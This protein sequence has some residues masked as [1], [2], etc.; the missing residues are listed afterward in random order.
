MFNISSFFAKFKKLGL[1]KEREK[2]AVLEVLR[3]V[4]PVEIK[5]EVVRIKDGIIRLSGSPALKSA[6]FLK[7]QEILEKIK[8]LT[9]KS[10]LD[11]R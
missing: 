11:I 8:S 9:D 3:E 6:V 1:D 2:A 7:K 4:L 5:D 10:F